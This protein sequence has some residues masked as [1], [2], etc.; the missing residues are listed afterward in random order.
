MVKDLATLKQAKAVVRNLA[1]FEQQGGIAMSSQT[2]GVQW[3]KPYGWAPVQMIAVEGM[4]R[5]GFN[6][7]ADRV[8]KKFLATVFEN[9]RREGTIREKY[10]LVTR[11]TEANVT[12]GYQANVVGFGW[13]NAA[14]LVMLHA[15]TPEDRKNLLHVNYRWRNSDAWNGCKN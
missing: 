7:E 4:R 6:S 14:F 12:A 13:T 2:T 9:Y 11:T 3:D 8:S 15:L 10:N 1:A 5:Y